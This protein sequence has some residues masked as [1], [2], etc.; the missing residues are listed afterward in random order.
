MA[1]SDT[2]NP[3]KLE[4]DLIGNCL[5]RMDI[6][7]PNTTET[8]SMTTLPTL[9][10]LM[11][12]ALAVLWVIGEVSNKPWLRRVAGP[13]FV[14][15]VAGIAAVASGISTSF[16]GSIRYSGAMKRFV[17]ALIQTAEVDGDAAAVE[18]LRRFDSISME[19]YEGGALLK[20][21]AE[22][23]KTKYNSP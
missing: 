1:G 6:L 15:F 12:L 9:T 4:D 11:T 23:L 17:S 22:P 14:V 16:D 19:T 10:L 18:K 20:W 3:A 13:F 5:L 2:D 21:L 7:E 8:D